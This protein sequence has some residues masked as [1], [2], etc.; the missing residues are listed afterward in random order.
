MTKL[1][2]IPSNKNIDKLVEYAD[3]FLIGLKDYSVNFGVYF[4]L[5]EIKEISEILKKNNK[6]LFV[7]I[8]KNMHYDDIENIKKII[9]ELDNLDIKGIFYY[10]TGIVNIHKNLKLKTPLVW[11]SEHLTTNYGT[12][13][14]WNK[15]GVDYTYLSSEI[16]LEEILEIKKNTKV[17]LIVPIFGYLPMFVSERHAVKNYLN[18]FKIKDES[19]INYIEKENN[20]YPIVDDKFGTTAYASK[21]LNGYNEYLIMKKNNIDY[22]TLNEFEIEEDKFIEVIRSFKKEDINTKEKIDSLFNNET[23]THF[24]H[25]ETIYKVKKNG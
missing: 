3:S 9:L 11:S 25:T 22:V 14:F 7:S 16:T 4:E 13:N 19:N 5:E 21:I 2:V 15:Y 20:V 18:N 12:I 8:N 1:M 17:S 24:L 6:E 10:D 23:S